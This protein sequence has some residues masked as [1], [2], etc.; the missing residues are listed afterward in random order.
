M[1]WRNYKLWIYIIV[2]AIVV[3]YVGLVYLCSGFDLH[4]CFGSSPT[5]ENKSTPEVSNNKTKG[6]IFF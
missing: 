4:G 6:K 5:V 1:W 2:F 3:I